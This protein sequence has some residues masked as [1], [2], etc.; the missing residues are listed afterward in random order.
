MLYNDVWNRW[1]MLSATPPPKL[2]YFFIIRLLFVS[3]GT[4][5]SVAA[6][7][8]TSWD[9]IYCIELSACIQCP[10]HRIHPMPF[11]NYMCRILRKFRNKG[12]HALKVL[13]EVFHVLKFARLFHRGQL[14]CTSRFIVKFKSNAEHAEEKTCIHI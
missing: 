9:L 14:I 6:C 5:E 4:C 10:L 2:I 7:L 3:L 8:R 13:Y 1:S 12:Y 11:S